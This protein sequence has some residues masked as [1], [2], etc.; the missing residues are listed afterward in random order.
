MGYVALPLTLADPKGLMRE[1]YRIDGIGAGECRSIFMDWAMGLGPEV[2]PRA[3]LRT[4]LAEY[5][6]PG[7][8]MTT[9]LHEGLDQ[10]AP[11]PIRRG[12]ARARR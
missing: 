7:H 5:G 3:A 6:V 4:L 1:S 12:G 2:D 10:R 8:P 9:L 11:A